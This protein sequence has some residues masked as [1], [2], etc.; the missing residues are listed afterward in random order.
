MINK[1]SANIAKGHIKFWSVKTLACLLKGAGFKDIS[2]LRVG[3]IPS[4]AKSMIAI[5]RK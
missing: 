4:L 5:A 1:E 2:F 3:R